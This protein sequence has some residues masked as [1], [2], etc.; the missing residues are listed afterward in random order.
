MNAE[1]GRREILS[2]YAAPG[3]FTAL[4]GGGG[5]FAA[6]PRSLP[7][8]C[9]VVQGVTIHP[10]M[11][12]LYGLR[13]EKLPLADLQLRTAGEIVARAL[14]RDSRPIGISREPARR[15]CG[16]CRHHSVLLCA[17]L[18]TQGV[19][20]RAR[21]GFAAYFERG[22]F[23]DHWVVEVWDAARAAWRLVDAQLDAVQRGAFRSEFDPTDVPRSE[24]LVA[25]DAWRRCRAGELDSSLFGILD[26]WGLWFVAGN[27]VRDVASLSK[28]ELLPWDVWGAMP[29]PGVDPSPAELDLFDRAAA[30]ALDPDRAHRELRA[31]HDERVEFRVPA[32]V[33]NLQTERDE[34]L[35][36]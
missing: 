9:L 36:E 25:G 16:N 15:F 14:A 6:L 12:P 8:L 35:P 32:R 5:A 19:P 24:F 13:G 30:L 27:L 31:L 17:L 28:R 2:Y 22:R 4:G 1:T 18:R 10:F 26:L 34:P 23:V 33:R 7:E 21:C 20:A 29:A 11:A 3:P